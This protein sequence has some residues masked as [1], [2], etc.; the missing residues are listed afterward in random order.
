MAD[1]RRER[2]RDQRSEI[3]ERE[4]MHDSEHPSSPKLGL[5]V[6]R[7]G[8]GLGLVRARLGLHN[9]LLFKPMFVGYFFD[10]QKLIKL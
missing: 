6:G 4:D 10:K 7:V 2:Q 3:R 1:L 8:L 9:L 5:W